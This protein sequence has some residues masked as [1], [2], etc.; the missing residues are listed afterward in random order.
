[1]NL[2][3]KIAL[4]LLALASATTAFAQ[5]SPGSATA[6]ASQPQSPEATQTLDAAFVP[7]V[8]S[9]TEALEV[10]SVTR[11][12]PYLRI[13]IKNV[14]DKSIYS[15][16]MSYHKSGQA[17]LFSYVMSDTKTALAPGEVY[18]YDHSFIPNSPLA[19]EPL[20][21]DA[22]LFEDGTGDGEEAKVKSL[23][24]LYLA[25]R[26]ELEHVTALVQSAI[27]E[28]EVETLENLNN[29][30]SKLSETPDYMQRLDL[31]GLAG[32]TLPSWKGTAMNLVREIEQRRNEDP[33]TSIKTKLV[34][35]EERFSKTL[36][37]F[38]GIN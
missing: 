7:S 5:Q 6:Q 18:K 8:T 34:K 30:L 19:L 38:P 35:I 21:F 37:K 13:R 36:A 2:T 22:V 27:N 12:D 23:Q 29:L 24:G 11:R 4:V 33:G 3:S 10:L 9:K 31:S 25:N 15:Y 20:V 32:L 26:K 17:L 14:S 28:P 1:M 16:R